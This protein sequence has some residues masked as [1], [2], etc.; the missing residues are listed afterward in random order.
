[1]WIVCERRLP[2]A[3]GKSLERYW[4]SLEVDL[5]NIKEICGKTKSSR[6]MWS[7]RRWLILSWLGAG[8]IMKGRRI[9]RSIR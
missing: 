5:A 1:M 4:V 7:L 9:R 3:L 2:I 6:E 8:M